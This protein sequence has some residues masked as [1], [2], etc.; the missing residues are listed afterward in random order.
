MEE[1]LK[2]RE[3]IKQKLEH[4]ARST[5]NANHRKL[6]SRLTKELEELD[7]RSRK[8]LTT[9]LLD[10]D[11]TLEKFDVSDVTKYTKKNGH[12][13]Y[14][15]WYSPIENEPVTFIGSENILKNYKI[16]PKS[17]RNEEI[18][19]ILCEEQENNDRIIK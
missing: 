5:N 10:G 15:T 2:K 9:K 8:L 11:L 19:K 16:F 13:L 4:L 7:E 3:I 14:P 17:M 18:R 1:I 6:R 12:V